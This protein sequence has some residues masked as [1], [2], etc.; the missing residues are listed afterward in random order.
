MDLPRDAR[1][2]E[3]RREMLDEF[4]VW[5]LKKHGLLID[6]SLLALAPDLPPPQP[7]TALPEEFRQPPAYVLVLA[8]A[9]GE[10]LMSL[11]NSGAVTFGPSY[12]EKA[13][14][15]TLWE[16][17]AAYLPGGMQGVEVREALED[18]VDF[19]NDCE[20]YR[21]DY[22]CRE[23]CAETHAPFAPKAE[24]LCP[25]HRGMAALKMP[26]PLALD[27]ARKA[28]AEVTSKIESYNV[29]DRP[30]S[31]PVRLL[32]EELRLR[33]LVEW[34]AERERKEQR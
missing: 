3:I 5:L 29:G 6:E 33:S 22:D 2:L 24:K 34:Y 20:R 16:V 4:S 9:S 30:Q 28:L 27:A 15:R 14:A 23:C 13:A 7:A 31:P 21:P 18:A 32:K 1:E 26:N 12:D 25:L 11:H 8:G 17:F 19:L 10:P